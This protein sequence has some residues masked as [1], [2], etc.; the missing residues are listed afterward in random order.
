MTKQQ[1][2]QSYFFFT[3][4]M[5]YQLDFNQSTERN[6]C[7]VVDPY[8]ALKS[9]SKS[10]PLIISFFLVATKILMFKETLLLPFTEKDNLDQ[11]QI[12]RK[13]VWV[14]KFLVPIYKINVPF[15]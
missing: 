4:L 10:H 14:M 2:Q 6:S 13:S 15:E 11:D 12:R 3:K 9:V 5:T 8:W 1:Q 7:L